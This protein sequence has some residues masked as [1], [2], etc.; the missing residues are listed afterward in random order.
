MRAIDQLGVSGVAGM[1]GTVI[2]GVTMRPDPQTLLTLRMWDIPQRGA[3]N[4]NGTVQSQLI[5]G[6]VGLP[7]TG[8]VRHRM[9]REQ[10]P[11]DGPPLQTWRL[12]SL[13]PNLGRCGS[14]RLDRRPLRLHHRL[15][16]K[17]PR[18]APM[19]QM[20]ACIPQIL[21]EACRARSGITTLSVAPLIHHDV[22]HEVMI[23]IALLA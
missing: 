5:V 1:S 10:D 19:I 7:M 15:S 11:P 6:V 12:L 22:P 16:M 8:G 18:H 2:R 9:I 13:R 14:L 4:V 17:I 3:M 20:C 23:H 21:T